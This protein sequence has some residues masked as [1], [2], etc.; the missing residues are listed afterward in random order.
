MRAIVAQ[1]GLKRMLVDNRSSVNIIFGAI[2]D[3]MEVDHTSDNI[4]PKG[5]ITFAVEIGTTALTPLHVMEFL[6]V[7]NCSAYHGYSKDRR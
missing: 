2:C 4:I 5:K 6:V 3:K 7:D 1:N